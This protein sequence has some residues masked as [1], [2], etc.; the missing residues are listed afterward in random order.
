MSEYATTLEDKVIDQ[1]AIETGGIL[2]SIFG[3]PVFASVLL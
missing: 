2:G 1:D 3:A